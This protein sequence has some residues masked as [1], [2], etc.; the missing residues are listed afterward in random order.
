MD[1]FERSSVNGDECAVFWI[2]EVGRSFESQH[3]AV[4]QLLFV[5]P[6]HEKVDVL[7][8]LSVEMPLVHADVVGKEGNVV[9]FLLGGENSPDVHQGGER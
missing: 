6:R 7:V 2:G 8:G 1:A 9:I 5:C 3:I 4:I